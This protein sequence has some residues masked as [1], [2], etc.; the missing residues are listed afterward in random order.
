LLY[1]QGWKD[2]EIPTMEEWLVRMTEFAEMAKLNCLIREKTSSISGWKPF[3]DFFAENGKNNN[4][5]LAT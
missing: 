1:A 5:G 3:M 4:N 2:S